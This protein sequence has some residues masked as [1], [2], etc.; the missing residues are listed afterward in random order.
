MDRHTQFLDVPQLKPMERDPGEYVGK[1]RFYNNWEWRI[2]GPCRFRI[3]LTGGAH[4]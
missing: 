3:N 2:V 1:H 4:R